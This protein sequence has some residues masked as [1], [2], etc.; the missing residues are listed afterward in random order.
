[1]G[2]I[3]VSYRPNGPGIRKIMKSREMQKLVGTH[4]EAVAERATS[5]GRGRYGSRSRV[6]AVSAHGYAFTA[7]YAAMLDN[8]RND[9]LDKALGGA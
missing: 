6:Q 5:M 9:T 7:N 4:A 8:A 3:N 2:R 1:M